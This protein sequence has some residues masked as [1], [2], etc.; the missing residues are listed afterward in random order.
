MGDKNSK[1]ALSRYLN[2]SNAYLCARIETVWWS[3]SIYIWIWLAFL[4]TR[5]FL[6]HVST[7]WKSSYLCYPLPMPMCNARTPLFN[8]FDYTRHTCTDIRLRMQKVHNTCNKINNDFMCWHHVHLCVSKKLV[9]KWKTAAA[10]ITHTH[11]FFLSRL[12]TSEHM[13]TYGCVCTESV[14]AQRTEQMQ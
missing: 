12:K 1:L 2:E 9:V 10:T 4:Y 3:E 13:N 7:F 14:E 6:L 11:A 8:G 5:F